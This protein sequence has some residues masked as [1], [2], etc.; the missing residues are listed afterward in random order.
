[1]HYNNNNYKVSEIQSYYKNESKNMINKIDISS[2][3]EDF[4]CDDDLKEIIKTNF[5][6]LQ[7]NKFNINFEGEQKDCP[8]PIKKPIDVDPPN[9]NIENN[10]EKDEDEEQ[11]DINEIDEEVINQTSE[12]FKNFMIHMIGI[13]SRTANIINFKD[14]FDIDFLKI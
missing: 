1:M 14:I 7:T 9:E 10:T 8:K 11:K 12:M 13:Y 5:K 6:I 2:L 4:L 3:L